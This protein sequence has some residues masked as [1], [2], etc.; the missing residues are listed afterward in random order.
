MSTRSSRSLQ[1]RLLKM[2]LALVALVWLSAAALTWYDAQHE[3]DELLDGHLA[4]A[5]SLLLELERSVD[6][7]GHE[8]TP[9]P[10]HGRDPQLQAPAVLHKYAGK[11]AFQ[12]FHQGILVSRSGQIDAAPL[13]RQKFGFETLRRID[14]TQ[15]RVFATPGHESG[16]RILVAEQTGLRDD[17]L[18]AVLRSVLKPLLFAL[19]LLMLAIWW[20]VR[21][22]LMPLRQLGLEVSRRQPH[23]TQPIAL[24]DTP[25]EVESLVHALNAL[26]ERIAHM[27]EMERRFTADAA[28]ELR[29]PIAAIRTQVQVAMS[30]NGAGRVHALDC[31]LAGCDRASHLVD[32]LLTLARLEAAPATPSTRFDLATLTRQIAAV[33]APAALARQQTLELDAPVPAELLGN[34]TL[35]GVLVRNLLDNALRYSAS[36]ATIHISVAALQQGALL[37]VQDSGPG[38]T[39]EQMANL[40]KRFFRVLGAEQTGS[41]LGWSIVRRVAQAHSADLTVMRSELLGGL[42]VGVQWRHPSTANT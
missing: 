7:A 13:T 9:G 31:A 4:Q 17:I 32:Q 3:L 12:V 15:W 21:R 35:V 28:H 36:G 42:D 20:S 29:T 26:F 8:L 11:I 23:R 14:G 24:T 5:A 6:N 34:E 1:G 39:E 38:M 27:M 22:G 19:P 10:D 37:R 41:G 2:V 18:W 16:I 30:A 25:L 33:V 40:G